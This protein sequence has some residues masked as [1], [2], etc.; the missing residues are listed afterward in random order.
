MKTNKPNPLTV[1]RAE[2]LAEGSDRRFRDFLH[3][4]LTFGHQLDDAL[5]AF[6]KFIGVTTPQYELLI[7]IRY[8]SG[9]GYV[10]ITRLAAALH[11]SG[12]FVTTEVVKLVKAGLVEKRRDAE[13][14]RCVLLRLTSEGHTR[15]EALAALQRPVNDAL[16]ECLDERAFNQLA[17]LSSRLVVCGDRGRALARYLVGKSGPLGVVDAA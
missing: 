17:E 6:A 9:G 3:A 16:F 1:S 15:F 14:R 7:N 2:L 12:A 13:D 5:A 10:N 11:C 8:L 4:L